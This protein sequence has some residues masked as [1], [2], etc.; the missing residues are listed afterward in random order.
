MII[1]YV[2]VQRLLNY[3]H[4][5]INVPFMTT[6]RFK[7]SDG[8]PQALCPALFTTWSHVI[9]ARNDNW[10]HKNIFCFYPIY[11]LSSAFSSSWEVN[12]LMIS[13]IW[14][15]IWWFSYYWALLTSPWGRYQWVCLQLTWK[16]RGVP[17]T[18][19]RWNE[20]LVTSRA[21]WQTFLVPPGTVCGNIL[22]KRHTLFLV[23]LR[24]F[25]RMSSSLHLRRDE[26]KR[27]S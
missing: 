12:S 22:P 7:G 4:F 5:K 3:L 8:R 11:Q 24:L 25:E 19:D 20:V 17:G 15:C 18:W 2:L 21:A 26:T 9:T 14:F 6:R 16:R 13:G 23:A 10:Q 27:L 1:H